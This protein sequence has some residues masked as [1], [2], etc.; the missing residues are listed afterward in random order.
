MSKYMSLMPP[1]QRKRQV[2][3]DLIDAIEGVVGVVPNDTRRILRLLIHDDVIDATRLYLDEVGNS[4][5]C[6][7]YD[8]PWDCI[9]ES[10]EKYETLHYGM[11]PGLRHDY[12]WD[13]QWCERCLKRKGTR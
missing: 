4:N 8:P 13:D 6:L 2:T 9:K 10:D 1:R 5:A 7:V 12:A 11:M 3:E